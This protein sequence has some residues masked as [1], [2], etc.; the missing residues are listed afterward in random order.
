VTAGALSGVPPTQT[1]GLAFVASPEVPKT[2]TRKHVSTAGSSPVTE[3]ESVPIGRSCGTPGVLSRRYLTLPSLGSSHAK[4]TEVSVLSVTTSDT[5]ARA[6]AAPEVSPVRPVELPEP[7]ENP[8]VRSPIAPEASAHTAPT[9][10]RETIA[11]IAATAA[12]KGRSRG[13]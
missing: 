5:G 4:V 13:R 6:A 9:A 8:P 3:I 12:R 10:P 2:A 11:A 1:A 7:S